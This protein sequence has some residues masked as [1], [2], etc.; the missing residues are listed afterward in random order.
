MTT[1]IQQLQDAAKK[2]LEALR[3]KAEAQLDRVLD[4]VGL[5]RKSRV[6]DKAAA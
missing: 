6:Q 4:R 2:R 5:V 1:R 3:P